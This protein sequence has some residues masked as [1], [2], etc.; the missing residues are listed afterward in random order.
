MKAQDGWKWF[1]MGLLAAGVGMA[2]TGCSDDDDDENSG[3][4]TTVV[5]NVVGGTTVVVTNVV[6]APVVP[7]AASILN[8]VGSWTGNYENENGST[9]FMMDLLQNGTA[10]RG[11]WA[12]LTA[13]DQH[14]NLSG[15]L[16]GDHLVL[17]LQGLVHLD[18]YVNA[19]ATKYIGAW[20]DSNGNSGTFSLEK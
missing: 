19:S 11:Q 3:G 8:V 13:V 15:T 7:P 9:P 6:A 16:A 4:G 12:T 2:T 1:W 17:A 20:S 10:I 5:T 18:G 14:G